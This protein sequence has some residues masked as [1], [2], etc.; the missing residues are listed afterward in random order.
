MLEG[1]IEASRTLIL[2]SVS[3]L[4]HLSIIGF[5]FICEGS[6]IEDIK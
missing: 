3:S 2:G 4:P 6:G 5:V 1:K